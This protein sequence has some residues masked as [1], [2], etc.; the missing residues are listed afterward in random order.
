MLSQVVEAR[1]DTDT[2]SRAAASGTLAGPL[3]QMS[4][5]QGKASGGSNGSSLPTNGSRGKWPR[6]L[7]AVVQT[8]P[9]GSRVQGSSM[10]SSGRRGALLS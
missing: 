2:V 5:V 1:L 7:A 6:W 4:T 3:L 9:E 10:N 8:E